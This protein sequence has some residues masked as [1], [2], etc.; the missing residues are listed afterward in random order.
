MGVGRAQRGKL[1]AVDL[2]KYFNSI[3]VSGEVGV[4][5]PEPEIYAIAE[6]RLPADQYV[7]VG[8]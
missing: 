4:R 2:T 3:V 5:K 8:E 1:D 7:F 6:Q